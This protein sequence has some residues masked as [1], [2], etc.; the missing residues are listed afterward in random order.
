LQLHTSIADTTLI[1]DRLVQTGARDCPATIRRDIQAATQVQ[2][3]D[4]TKRL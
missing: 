3:P 2:G 1:I 4:F